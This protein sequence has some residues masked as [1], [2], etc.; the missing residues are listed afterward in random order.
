MLHMLLIY[1]SSHQDSEPLFLEDMGRYHS[2]PP[3][4]PHDPTLSS[5]LSADLPGNTNSR[6]CAAPE[7]LD[8]QV[9]AHAATASGNETLNTT[10]LEDLWDRDNIHLKDLKLTTD[11]IK[12]LQDASLDDPTMGLFTDELEVAHRDIRNL[13]LRQSKEIRGMICSVLRNA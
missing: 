4:L 5:N 13:E 6:D 3:G 8:A 1:L 9:D 12:A 7:Q 2:P 10:N 11:F